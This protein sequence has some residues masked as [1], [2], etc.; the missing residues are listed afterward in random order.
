[1]SEQPPF[2]EA[3]L[4][5]RVAL[6]YRGLGSG[7]PRALDEWPQIELIDEAS[8]NQFTARV[9]RPQVQWAGAT[10]PVAPQVEAPV[11]EQVAEQVTEQVT[12]QVRRLCMALGQEANGTK[13]LMQLLNLKHRPSFLEGYLNPALQ[14]HLVEMTQPDSPRSPTQKYRLTEQGRA[15]LK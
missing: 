1:M 6:P 8:G 3:A 4:L 2:T 10:D 15:L 7:I 9:S 14:Q 13:A 5:D 11:I 12:E